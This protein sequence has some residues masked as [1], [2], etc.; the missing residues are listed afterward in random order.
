MKKQN[1]IH[2]HAA[3]LVTLMVLLV[4]AIGILMITQNGS[5]PIGNLLAVSKKTGATVVITGLDLNDYLGTDVSSLTSSEL[6]YLPTKTAHNSEGGTSIYQT[7]RLRS[8]L[9]P[10]LDGG[11]IVY[12]E[13]DNGNVADFL[14]FTQNA[15]LFEFE[16]TFSSGL[17]SSID[18]NSLPDL[19]NVNIPLLGEDYTITK[20]TVNTATNRI[21]IVMYG[22][23]GEVRLEDTDY[24]DSQFVR[25]VKVNG[26]SVDAQVQI[27][28]SEIGSKV[29][30]ASIKY[31]PLAE[32]NVGGDV[33]VRANYGVRGQL[34]NKGEL[35]NPSFDIIY[36]GLGG[37]SSASSIS[38][39]TV[40][41]SGNLARLLPIGGSRYNLLFTN[42][43]GQAYNVPLVE[44]S[45]GSFVTGEGDRRLVAVEAS[46]NQSYN[47]NE[48]DYLILTSNNDINGVTNILRLN[49]VQFDQKEVFIDDLAGGSKTVSLND[50]GYGVLI[51][52]GAQFGI[53]ADPSGAAQIAVD[54]T[55]D[56]VFDGTR[57][58]IVV[59]GGAMLETSSSSL[60]LRVPQKL[61]HERTV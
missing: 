48:G 40:L 27:R 17:V 11:Q 47:V 3:A 61:F 37:S 23:V 53:Y 46:S 28:A 25:G 30:I 52:A 51:T 57:A 12:Q 9:S 16:D 54:Q 44:Y 49:Q 1:D 8:T 24:T 56:G 43:R 35:L 7:L 55:G 2:Y 60:V 50:A 29:S 20:S 33:Y 41:A 45:G 10:S 5:M 42:T 38:G 36:G 34:K 18:T 22:P 13:D 19:E 6:G 26:R 21:E 39:R 15:P 14:K 32:K 31:R 4:G 59:S 58:K